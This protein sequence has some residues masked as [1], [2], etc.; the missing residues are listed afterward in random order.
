V[1][2]D[3]ANNNAASSGKRLGGITG[4]GFLLGKCVDK[5]YQQIAF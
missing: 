1:S 3:V 5:H 4:K 2:Q